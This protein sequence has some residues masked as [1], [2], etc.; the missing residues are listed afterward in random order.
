MRVGGEVPLGRVG[1]GAVVETPHQFFDWVVVGKTDLAGRTGGDSVRASVLH[2]LDEVLVALLRE[3][4]ALL[5]VQVHVV[6]PNL[7]GGTVSVVGELRAQVEVKAYFVVLKRNKWEVKT[8]VAVEEED[9][10]E[11]D[12]LGRTDTNGLG[13][14]LTP[15]S[16]L[17]FIQVKLG[18][19]TPPELVVLVNTLTANGQ[20]NGLN[21][22]LG[23][24][25]TGE[26]DGTTSELEAGS[27]N[28]FN[29]HVTNQ[30]AI[31]SNSDGH[32]TVVG[33]GTVDSLFDVFHRKVSVALVDR[34]EEGN[35]RVASQVDVLGTV[36]DKLHETTSHCKFLYYIP[37]FFFE[38]KLFR[39]AKF[40]HLN[41][42]FLLYIMSQPEPKEE[43]PEEIDETEDE[44]YISEQFDEEDDL[45]LEE[46]EFD[47]DEMDFDEGVD[48]GG[49][50]GATLATEDGDTVCSAL[51]TIGDQLATQNKILLKILSSLSKK[52]S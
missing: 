13:G 49:L 44:E 19:Q 51:V 21:S 16:L 17:G 52:D 11:E 40:L 2:L 30:V 39:T 5:G 41:F 1:N 3:S 23:R 42:L 33:R 50:L 6:T 12:S 34:L 10:W 28:E 27:G 26:F 35:L 37:R 24:P 4:S 25:A 8:W 18:V 45:E 22:T 20:L 32:A 15:R 48:L 36:R 43:I 31:T 9:E 7:E 14:H 38:I 29:I 47:D 46:G